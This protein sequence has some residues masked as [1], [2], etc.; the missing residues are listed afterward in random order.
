MVPCAVLLWEVCTGELPERGQMRPLEA[1]VDCPQ[2]IVVL[3]QRCVATDP[4][5]RPDSAEVVEVLRQHQQRLSLDYRPLLAG[6]TRRPSR[7]SPVRTATVLRSVT[8]PERPMASPLSASPLSAISSFYS[9]GSSWAQYQQPL[10]AAASSDAAAPGSTAEVALAAAARNNLS[11]SSRGS[12]S[13][14]STPMAPLA[15]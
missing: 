7:T 6:L 14:R 11:C 9:A 3:Q 5:L 12:S 2:S 1:P 10:Q 15:L 13:G 8:L 4:S